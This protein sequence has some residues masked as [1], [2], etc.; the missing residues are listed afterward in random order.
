MYLG[1][2]SLNYQNQYSIRGVRFTIV[3]VAEGWDF[4][5]EVGRCPARERGMKRKR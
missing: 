3:I 4:F 5:L 1:V 2:G